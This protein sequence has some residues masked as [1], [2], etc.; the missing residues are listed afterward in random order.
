M[1][2]PVDLL[3]IAEGLAARIPRER[4]YAAER[5]ACW[6]AIGEAWLKLDDFPSALRALRQLDDG[7]AQAQFRTAAGMWAG[8]HPNSQPACDLLRETLSLVDSVDRKSVV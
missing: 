3:A 2:T 6:L 7:D 4:D 8:D 5:N 1:L